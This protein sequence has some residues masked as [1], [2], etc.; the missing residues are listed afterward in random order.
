MEPREVTVAAN[1]RVGPDTVALDLETPEGFSAEP[2]QFVKLTLEVEGEPVSRFYTLSSPSV[3]DTF[4][5]TV[6][7]DPEGDVA[8]HLE[9]L[10][11]GD[12]VQI[13]G[14]FGNDYYEGESRV[15]I[16]AGGPGVGAAIGIAERAVAE[17]GEAGLVYQDD[18]PV[19][20]DRLAALTE[21]GAAV[22]ILTDDE[23]MTDAVASVLTGDEQLFIY[24]FA[25]FLDA[26]T[27]A[28]Q[29][30]GADPETAKVENFG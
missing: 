23:D 22:H 20:E 2:G 19:H 1:R 4:E 17:G 26:A 3:A 11:A 25:D 14:P 16:L 12:V 29:E 30:A 8:P 9:A 10:E 28:L 15:V 27:T 21:K 13:A 18:A 6:G 5:I 24:G 7:I